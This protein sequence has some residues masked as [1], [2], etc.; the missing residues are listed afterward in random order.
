M[1]FTFAWLRMLSFNDCKRAKLLIV[2]TP[3]ASI[4]LPRRVAQ[5]GV[6]LRSAGTRGGLERKLDL[7]LYERR[8]YP[9]TQLRRESQHPRSFNRGMLVCVSVSRRLQTELVAQDSC[10]G[11]Q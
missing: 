8:F 9:G 11:V 10:E 4:I 2:E 3:L 7:V 1:A 5:R 6:I